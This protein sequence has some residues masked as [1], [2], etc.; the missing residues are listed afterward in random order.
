MVQVLI[1]YST[2][3]GNTEKLARAIAVGVEN[4]GGTPVL[5]RAADVVKEDLLAADG[6]IF[7]SPVYFGTP[8]AELKDL[9]DRT[10]TV[11]RKLRDKVGAAFTTSGNLTGGKETTMLAIHLAFFIHEMIIV[12]DPIEA[13]G[14]FGVACKGAPQPDDERCGELLG[15]RVCKV[16]A[17]MKA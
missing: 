16:A 10:V 12:G 2:K 11:R 8:T 6:L 13:G 9:I 15:E 4:A 1:A 14:H 17:K 3:S 5:K 7:G